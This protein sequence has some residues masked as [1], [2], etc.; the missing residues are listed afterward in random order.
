MKSAFEALLANMGVKSWKVT[1]AKHPS[2]VEGRAA[3]VS[4]ENQLIGIVGEIHPEV[5]NN[6]ALEN[7]V[8]ALEIDLAFMD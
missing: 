3:T 6:F 8:A 2:F 5:L 7:P 4:I 1:A